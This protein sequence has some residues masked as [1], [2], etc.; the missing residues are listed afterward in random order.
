M[1]LPIRG[2]Q[3]FVTDEGTGTP[4]LFAHSLFFDHTMFDAQ[5]AALSAHFRVIRYDHRGQGQSS[6]APREALTIPELTLDAAALIEALGATPCHF[7]GNSLGGFIALHLA[8]RHPGLLRSVTILGSSGEP[9]AKIAEFDPLVAAMAQGVA[10]LTDTIMHIM[11]GDSFLAD[12]ARAAE[13][14]HWR[15]KIAALPPTIADAAHGVVHRPGILG[16]LRGTTIPILAIAGGQDHAYSLA[17]AQAVAAAANGRCEC[18]P[19]AG[20]SVALEAPALTNALLTQHFAAAERT[21]P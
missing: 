16:Q 4:V 9:E 5:A 12:P 10:P 14:A 21:A 7:V 1:L 15:A 18:I 3:I 17:N 13:R 19:Q 20:H 2:G 6:P 11:F 8:A